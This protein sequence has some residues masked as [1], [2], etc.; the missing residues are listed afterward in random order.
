MNL[1]TW[2]RHHAAYR[3]VRITLGV[4]AAILAVFLVTLITVDLGRVSVPFLETDASGSFRFC[5][6]CRINLQQYAET[7]GRN[8]WKRP[9]HIGRLSVRLLT[10]HILVE[11]FSIEGLRPTDRPFFTANRLEVTLDW[12]TLMRREVTITSVD[13]TDWQMLAEKWENRNSFPKFTNDDQQQDQGPKRFTT[14]L[15]YL[16]AWR[17]QFAYEDHE[18][19][20]SIVARNLEINIG[21][22][23]SYHGTAT[24]SGGTVAIQ[25]DVPFGASMKARFTLDGGRVHLER[26]DFETDGAKTTATGD[27]D[28]GHWPEQRY[29]FKSRVQFPRMRQIFFKDERWELA[30]DGDF[31][32]TFHLFKGGHDLAG[33]FASATIGVNEYRFP[34]LY[35]SLHWTRTALDITNAGAKLFGGDGRFTYSMQPLGSMVRPTARFEASFDG[36]DVPSFTD[37]EQLKGLRFAGTAAA[38]HVVLEWPLGR[39]DQHRGSGHLFVTPPAGTQPMTA[40]RPS[41]GSGRPEALEGRAAD[42]STSSGSSRAQ[43]RDDRSRALREWGPFAPIPLPRHLPVAGELTYRFDPGQVYIEPSRFATEHTDVTFQGSTAW[44]DRSLLAFHVTSSDWQESDQVLAGLMTDFGAA[45]SPVT[46]GGRGEFDGTMTGP[47][48]KPRVE[49]EFS[50]E[51]LRGFD[52]VW[53]A[54][55]A[56]ILVDNGYVRVTDGIVKQND[57]DM[58]FDGLFSLGFPRDDGG[59]EINARIRVVRRDVD[60]LR[61]AFGID[62]YPVSGLLSGEFHLTGEY[63]RPVG[64]GGMTLEKLV[65][66]GEPFDAATASLRFDGLGVRLDDLRVDKAGGTITGAAFIGWDATYSFNVDGRRIPVEKISKLAYARARLSGIA[67]LSASGSGTFDQPRNDYKFRVNDLFIG[68]EGVGQVTGSLVLRG[69]ALGGEIDAASPRLAITATGQVAMTARAESDI[70]VR[71][72]DMSLDPYVRPFVPRLSPFTTAVASGS[73]RI[74]GRLT[75]IDHLVVDGR[76]DSLDMR[77]FDYALKNAAPIRISLDDRV[78]TLE[79]L[80]LIGEDTR[81]RVAGTIGLGD[82]R[83]AL[84]AQG[85][86]NLGIL[87]AFFRSDLRGSGHA[88][89]TAAI[90]G[91]LR[92]P[93]FSGRATITDGRIRH[94]SLPHSLDA[95]NGVIQFDA[96]GIRLDELTATM[97][98]GPVQFGGRIGF[99]GYGPGELNVTVRGSDVQL[100]YPEGV[101]SVIDADL[102]VRGNFKAPTIGGTVTVKSAVYTKRIDAPETL[103]DFAFRRSADVSAGA[104]DVPTAAATIP[105]RFDLRIVV[106]STLRIDNNLARGVASADL[107]LRGTYDRPVWFGHAQVERGELTYKGKRYRVTRGTIDFTN[108]TRV[109]PFFD[110]EAETNVRVAGQNY[111]LTAGV[112]GATEKKLVPSLSSDPPLPAADILALLFS[113]VRRTGDVELRTLNPTQRQADLISANAAETIAKPI[114]DAGKVVQRAVGVDTFQLTP[115][116]T[117]VNSTQAS[118]LNP[119]A[120]LTI[121]KRISDRVYLTFSRSLASSIND[122]IILLE[123]DANERMSWMLSRN[124]DQQTYAL[125]FRVRHA[126]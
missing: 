118:R 60:S 108:P 111:R 122:Q 51:D 48:R 49:G 67:E 19:P 107:T 7:L 1:Y 70:T 88:E 6:R 27:V 112:T 56:H 10:G 63:L 104:V 101:R 113:D 74:A 76:I 68:E 84:Q 32:G 8:T 53:G 24:F 121:G 20:W 29:Q 100:R 69:A 89:L 37:F 36:V 103:L 26:V 93:V 50:G 18:A 40:A 28:L 98:G 99:E 83:I 92:E 2:L 57:S 21:N 52:T 17:G 15:K 16:R 9:I 64:F 71:F 55:E 23:P 62:D 78:V 105:L 4:A 81:L 38:D 61:H 25:N 80:E 34:E 35:G 14:T 45:T 33:T 90:S 73:M 65:A 102:A 85:D 42:P 5:A 54:G 3:Y 58:R 110:I 31:T 123:Y 115:F 114:A 91:P 120:R 59:E 13:M 125:E 94:F 66:Y 44:G 43:S 109:E 124:E 95:I 82:E 30:G 77:L 39:F 47:F 72:H 87:Q 106:P 75:D 119:T 126:F 86:A 79:G 22:L 96:N 11:N 116:L 46:F 97:G 12:T 117:D 41:T